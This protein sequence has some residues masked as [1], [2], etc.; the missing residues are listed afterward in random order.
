MPLIAQ[1]QEGVILFED[2]FS[3]PASGWEIGEWENGG[4]GYNEGH[5]FIITANNSYAWEGASQNF[6]DISIA[7]EATQVLAPENNNNGYGVMCRLQG[8]DDG[9]ILIIGDGYASIIKIENGES[10][11]LVDWTESSAINP[12]NSSNQLQAV[13]AGSS[14]QLFA[15]GELVAEAQDSSFTE[16]DIGL[17]ATTYEVDPTEIH[18]DNLAVSSAAP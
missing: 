9:Y 6:T 15:N 5:Y 10:I 3:D 13:C 8:N 11:V 4:D 2:D 16:G 7:V 17:Y 12:G 14:L 18:F 1:A